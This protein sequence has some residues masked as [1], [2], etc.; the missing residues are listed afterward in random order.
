M[1]FEYEPYKIACIINL[2][3]NE[4]YFL[5]HIQF[6]N[7]TEFEEEDYKLNSYNRYRNLVKYK[8][9]SKHHAKK[10]LATYKSDVNNFLRLCDKKI[11]R[12]LGTDV[13]LIIKGKKEKN[14]EKLKDEVLRKLSPI[15]TM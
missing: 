6:E 2:K 14:Y 5:N 3:E 1:V 9:T 13:L 4:L 11:F 7:P 8:D 12:V 15:M 10:D